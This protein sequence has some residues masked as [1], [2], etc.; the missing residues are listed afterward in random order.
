LALGCEGDGVGFETVLAE[1]GREGFVGCSGGGTLFADSSRTLLRIFDVSGVTGVFAVA[2]LGVAGGFGGATFGGT[3]GDVALGG[4]AGFVTGF[5]TAFSA[6]IGFGGAAADA[7]TAFGAAFVD[8]ARV[9]DFL[10]S[11]TS[12]TTKSEIAFLGLPLFLATSE[13]M[14]DEELGVEELWLRVDS[15]G[16]F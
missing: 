13:D 6:I 4:T 14:L 10:V 8:F 16:Q 5:R 7:F 11:G 3:G 2:F 15:K 9:V 12:T 1:D